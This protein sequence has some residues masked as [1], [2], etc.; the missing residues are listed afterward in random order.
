MLSTKIW[1]LF[2]KPLCRNTRFG[3]QRILEWMAVELCNESNDG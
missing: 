2:L 3:S 1:G